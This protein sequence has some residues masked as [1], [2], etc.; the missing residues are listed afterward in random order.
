MSIS[1]KK[2]KKERARNRERERETSRNLTQKPSKTHGM[3]FDLFF[4]VAN[5]SS[6]AT[7][8]RDSNQ[9]FQVDVSRCR[10][11]NVLV[12]LIG[13]GDS[14]PTCLGL[15]SLNQKQVWMELHIST[16]CYVKRTKPPS[17][18]SV[19]PKHRAVLL[20]LYGFT[21]FYPTKPQKKNSIYGALYIYIIYIYT[22][23]LQQVTN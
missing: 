18:N 22:S 8:L 2:T 3:N 19:I 4:L 6:S 16:T 15:P 13:P 21:E 9:L 14:G 12:F 20:R 23:T 11:S 7:I 10:R 1:T 5:P 17:F